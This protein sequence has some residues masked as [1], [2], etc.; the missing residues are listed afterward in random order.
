MPL[1]ERE[2]DV[3]VWLLRR[4][5]GLRTHG[6]QV[7][8]PGGK[9]DAS[10]ESPLAT[11]LREAQEEIGLEPRHVD[12]LGR[13]EDLQTITG[14]SIAPFVGW[15]TGDGPGR[16]SAWHPVPN[17]GEVA[18]TFAAPLRAFL[19]TPQGILPKRGYT[20]DGELV[21]GATAKMLRGLAAL[22]S[23]LVNAP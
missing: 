6:G 8:L 9:A 10:D 17:V 2:G 5:S 20:I 1:F 3:F 15:L 11:A 14:F 16:A 19:E 18:R 22:V 13:L 7:A 4:A 21:W 12:V 23:E